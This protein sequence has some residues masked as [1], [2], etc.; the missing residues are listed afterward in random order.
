[1]FHVSPFMEMDQEYEWR[2][3]DPAAR[4]LVHMKNAKAAEKIFDATLL[5][6]REEISSRSL[7][8][9]LT[10]YPWMTAR[11]AAGIYWQALRLRLKRTP[12]HAHSDTRVA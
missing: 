12:Y 1:V 7:A 11:V 4:L 9:A 6:H 5:L 8:S 2:F 3:S 10:Q